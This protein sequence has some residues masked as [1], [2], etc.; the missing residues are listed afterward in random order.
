VPSPA[1]EAQPELRE[2]KGHV[3]DS[4]PQIVNEGGFRYC[5][6]WR[7]SIP[8]RKLDDSL[9]GKLQVPGAPKV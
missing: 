3:G 1:G 8:F 7:V 6:V 2:G 5:L 4:L 9:L